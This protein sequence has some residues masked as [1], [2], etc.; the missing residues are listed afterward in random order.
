MPAPTRVQRNIRQVVPF[1]WVHDLPGSLRFYIDGLGFRVTKQWE[2]DGR[3]RWCWLERDDVALM[4]QEFWREGH[5]AN[6]PTGPVGVGV[7]IAFMCEDAVAVYQDVTA[8]GVAVRR[9]FVAN[10]L[11]VTEVTDP[12]GYRLV[13]ES[14]TDAPEESILPDDA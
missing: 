8:Q 9:P 13:F 10:G 5:H 1:F 6:V 11:W 7:S 12:D 2:A 14:V 3:L 4:L